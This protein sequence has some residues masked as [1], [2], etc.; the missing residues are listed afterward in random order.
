[1]KMD[2]KTL[3]VIGSTGD[4]KSTFLNAIVSNENT[5]GEGI[6]ANSV[7][8]KTEK[9][10]CRFQGSGDEI[11]LCDTQGLSESEGAD[12]N[13]IKQMVEELKTLDYLNMVVIVINGTNVR[14]S[15]YLQETMQ[16]F[17]NMFSTNVLKHMVIVFTHW[18]ITQYDKDKERRIE[19]EYNEKFRGMF[20][21]TSEIPCFFIDSC[22]N[23]LNIRGKYTYDNEDREVYSARFKTFYGT[24]V[25]MDKLDTEVLK[26]VHPTI[27]ST[28]IE[29]K[30]IEVSR[31]VTPIL[32]ER[33]KR[34]G[35]LGG[36]ISINGSGY[37]T[38]TAHVGNRTT[39]Y[40]REEQRTVNTM[41][42]GRE[43]FGD[44]TV[45]RQWSTTN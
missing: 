16:L 13:H 25:S 36:F 26:Q 20:N 41:Y 3:V 2:C 33:E 14:F 4:G 28:R 7:T 30:T 43:E 44:W 34:R 45:I 35:G 42:S 31:T 38:Y 5:F 23:R 8:Q 17:I 10:R 37:K 27:K 29:K 22:Y 9:K 6:G 15:V 24:L 18:N 12:L 21:T 11:M 19:Q 40:W 1:M 39:I 32:E